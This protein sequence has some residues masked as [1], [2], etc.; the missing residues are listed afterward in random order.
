MTPYTESFLILESM[1]W[2]VFYFGIPTL[3]FS[4]IMYGLMKSS[5]SNIPKSEVKNE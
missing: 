3:I 5:T 4:L 2:F 1:A